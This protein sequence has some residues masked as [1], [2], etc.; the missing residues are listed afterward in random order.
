VKGLKINHLEEVLYLNDYLIITKTE[1]WLGAVLQKKGLNLTKADL[2]SNDL[3][4][5]YVI[6]TQ[7]I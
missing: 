4:T 7:G 1:I 2:L 5:P 6:T 3:T